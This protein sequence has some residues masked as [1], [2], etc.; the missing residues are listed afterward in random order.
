M[1]QDYE[2]CRLEKLIG[3]TAD[4]GVFSEYGEWFK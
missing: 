4:V 1:V 2:P 3:R